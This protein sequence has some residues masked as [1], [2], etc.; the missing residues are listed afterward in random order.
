MRVALKP[1][2]E[3]TIVL[4]GATS[5][6]GLATAR[7]AAGQGA[8][9]VLAAREPESLHRL[10]DELRARGTEVAIVAA[11]VG[12]RDDVRRIAQ[13]AIERF[14]GFDTWVNDAGVSIWGRLEEVS[15][16]DS[17]RLFDTNFWGMVHGS[18]EAVAVLKERGGALV[19]VG[20]VASEVSFPLQGMYCASKHAIK[21][22]TETLRIE[23]EDEEAPVSVTLIKPAAIDTPFPAHAR[24]YMAEEPKLPPPV[25]PPEDV[26]RA[27]LFAATHRRREIYVGGAGKAMSAQQKLAPALLERTLGAVGFDMQKRREPA[28]HREGALH[29]GRGGL[30]ERGDHPGHVARTSLYTRASLHPWL[31]TA[32][33][34]ATGIAIVGAI[35]V[36]R[37]RA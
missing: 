8:R 36:A 15:D 31:T 11:D 25:Y 10:A 4:T 13:T 9:L 34:G 1:I 37:A 3:Q 35:G 19:N 32:I 29:R 24:N 2:A 12:R 20:S 26:A 21:A 33:V 28:R 18:L 5:G 27:I 22:F 30:R 6:I 23:L 16:E 14:G 7:L 17:R